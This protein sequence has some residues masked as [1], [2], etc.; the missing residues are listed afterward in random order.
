MAP[1]GA[2]AAGRGAQGDRHLARPGRL[3]RRADR[4][5]LQEGPPG[6]HGLSARASSRLE[7]ELARHGPRGRTRA[8]PGRRRRGPARRGRRR[9]AAGARGA[10]AHAARGRRHAARRR[11]GRERGRPRPHP[12]AAPHRR[13]PRPAARPPPRR[14]AGRARAARRGRTPPRPRARRRTGVTGAARAPTGTASTPGTRARSGASA[15]HATTR[16]TTATS[17]APAPRSPSAR[18]RAATV[19]ASHSPRAP[20][21]LRP[22]VASILRRNGD[23]S[24]P[25]RPDA[26][27][28]HR[29][30]GRAPGPDPRERRA[31][32]RGQRR[33]RRPPRVGHAPDRLRGAQ[34]HRGGLPP[35]PVPRSA[36]AARAAG[37]QPED[38]GRHPAPPDHQAAP[39][40]PAPAGPQR[41]RHAAAAPAAD[42]AEALDAPLAPHRARSRSAPRSQQNSPICGAEPDSPG[43]APRLGR[44]TSF[45]RPRAKGAISWLRRTSTALSSRA[46]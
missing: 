33:D 13:R 32:D 26:P 11:G 7:A 46:T 4:G 21:G 6:P 39:G 2:R 12:H 5:H 42:P 16:A 15:G 41:R 38:H 24:T 17:R 20:A 18:A 1:R 19:H 14:R 9:G 28:R 29:D 40:H 22:R 30:G 31:R 44:P 45:K 23:R 8:A 36:R 35:A 43:P 3:D 37:P 27:P 34:A 25:L 10:A